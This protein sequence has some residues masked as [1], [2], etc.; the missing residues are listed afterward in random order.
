T[1]IT[2]ASGQCFFRFSATLRM[3]FRFTDRRS[4]RDIPGLR[5]TP[6]VMM[7]TSAPAQSAQFDVPLTF[8]SCPRMVPF[9]SRSSAFPFATPSFSGM[10]NSTTSPS[11]WRA[12]S[13]ARS[14]P[15][16]PAPIRAILFLRDIRNSS[17]RVEL[18]VVDDRVAEGRTRDF[19]GAFH[20][21]R[22]I[23]GDDLLRNGLL[24]RGDDLVG[25]ALPAQVL[26]Q[27]D[28][29]QDHRPR[30]HLVEVRVLRGGSVRR[31]EHG[32]PGRVVD[33]AARRD[34]DAAHLRGQRVAEVVAVQVQRRDDVELAGALARVL[35]RDLRDAVLARRLAGRG[36]A[37]A[38]VPADRLARVVALREG[39]APVAEAALGELH[40]VALVHQGDALALVADGVV[41]GRLDQALAALA[42]H[43]LD[44]DA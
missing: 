17:L 25:G 37:A 5:G 38:V 34:A 8:A 12:H 39:V 13:A 10:S 28:A 26:E 32:V 2:N 35:Q 14:P 3:I 41:E 21:A 11:S 19:F 24:E 6:A 20:Q 42:R 4:S 15:M 18:E 9:C 16:L 33:V 43:G 23:V 29:R 44:A 31:L 22:K 27:H 1:T 40:D 7:T 36:L 30:V